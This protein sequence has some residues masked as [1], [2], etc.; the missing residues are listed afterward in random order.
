MNKK[1]RYILILLVISIVF[2]MYELPISAAETTSITS[3]AIYNL[4]AVHSGKYLNV[5]YGIDSNGTNVYQW[6]F[7]GSTEQQFKV[8]YNSLND[9]YKFYSMSS[10]SGVNRVVDCKRINGGFAS[11][12]NVQLWDNIDPQAQEFKIIK[13]S[14]NKYKIVLNYNQNLALSV[15]NSSTQNGTGSGA[16][17]SSSGNVIISNYVG[18]NNQLWNFETVDSTYNHLTINYNPSK[19][20][21]AL[22]NRMNCYGYALQ[23]FYSGRIPYVCDWYGVLYDEYAYKQ[24]PGEFRINSESYGLLYQSYIK[25]FTLWYNADQFIYDRM[26]EDFQ[27]LGYDIKPTNEVNSV[28][29][30]PAGK[31]KIAL[32][33]GYARKD[34]HY[35]IQHSDGTWSHKPGSTNITN[36]SFDDNVI[37][38]NSNIAT[39]GKQGGYTDNIKFYLIDKTSTTD[40]PHG[41]GQNYNSYGSTFYFKDKA[42]DDISK[43]VPVTLNTLYGN[44]DH[45]KDEDYYKFTASRTGSHSIRVLGTESSVIYD[46]DAVVYRKDL[47]VIA[48]DTSTNSY[49]DINVYLN[50]GET[51]YINIA[52]WR[53]N[54][55]AAYWIDVD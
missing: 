34:Y 9:T 10:S 18:D 46:I 52:D 14:S 1:K 23:T 44:L 16:G 43:A 13:V 33:I 20:N 15:A 25:A 55:G 7:D 8:A 22:V 31:R 50:S 48:S 39:K 21:G 45:E 47:S 29:Q 32:V 40:Y 38:T 28:A 19:F 51:Y 26:V 42:G 41:A 54:F 5:H 37:L 12:S 30:A 11:G 17:S 3:G 27:R 49:V 24:Q 36:R 53:N 2:F 35:Y 4:K 6:S